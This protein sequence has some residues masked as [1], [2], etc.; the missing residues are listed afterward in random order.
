MSTT[1]PNILLIYT[2]GTIG[3]VKDFKTGVLRAFNFKNILKRIPEL[4][5]LDCNIDTVSFKEPID[6]SNMNPEYWVQIA[7]LI[8]KHYHDN[9][10]F[11]VLHGSDTMSYTASAL[12][13]MLENLAKPVV[14]TGSQLPIGDLRT[15]AKEN[16]ITSI[17]VA[18]LQ[19]RKKPVIK[20]VCLYFE[21]KLYRA[22]RTTKINAE[23]FEAFASLNYPD[24]AESG[25]HLKVNNEYLFKPNVNKKLVVHKNL[26]KN[27]ALVK[28]FPGISEAVL[29]SVFNTPN[30]KGVILETYGAGNCTTEAWFINIL[31]NAIKKGIHIINVTQCSGGSVIMGH[32]ETSNQL[33]KIGV[34][35]G[36]DITTEAAVSKLMYLVGQNISHN[37]FKIS[38]EIALRGEIT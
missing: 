19:H 33:K 1:K 14:F 11:V 10:G 29:Q 27:I 35:S 26:D 32:Y 9:D 25:V 8:E 5:L 31:K 28:L 37:A 6:S 36:K 16:L 15:D 24:L 38:Y 2:G 7:E 23:H 30:L 13:F 22:N 12:S 4:N 18:S 3:M 34:I 21:Y 20:E 17:Q